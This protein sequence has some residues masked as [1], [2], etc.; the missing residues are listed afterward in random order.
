MFT[1]IHIISLG[2]S[3]H[4]SKNTTTLKIHDPNDPKCIQNLTS[5]RYKINK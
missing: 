4:N 5:V 1:D 2:I 3:D